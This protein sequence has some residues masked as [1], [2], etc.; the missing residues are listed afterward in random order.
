MKK[1]VSHLCFGSFQKLCSE[2]R[3]ISNVSWLGHNSTLSIPW[4]STTMT[5]SLLWDNQNIL[6]N[7]WDSSQI[8]ATLCD[9]IAASHM[10][11]FSNGTVFST[12]SG[13]LINSCNIVIPDPRGRGSHMVVLDNRSLIKLGDDSNVLLLYIGEFIFHACI[14]Y[15]QVESQWAIIVK[16][17]SILNACKIVWIERHVAVLWSHH[18][19][20]IFQQ[21]CHFSSLQ[22]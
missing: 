6:V 21:A 22:I 4:G 1:S 8:P 12:C 11:T 9:L 3:I 18:R 17:T 10:I 20:Y 14:S 13:D 2:W 16:M 19:N 5:L 15:H 7:C